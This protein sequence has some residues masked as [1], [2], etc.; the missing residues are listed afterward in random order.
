MSNSI[1]PIP[2]SS[3]GATSEV[4]DPEGPTEVSRSRQKELAAQLFK[5]LA[6]TPLPSAT[7]EDKPIT[8]P[9]VYG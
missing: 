7:P 4:S 8:T 9:R 1:Q 5:E 3:V 2:S 6:L